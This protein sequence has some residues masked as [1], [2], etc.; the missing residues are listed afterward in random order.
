MKTSWIYLK[1][2]L[3][4][5]VI[6]PVCS[7]L[8]YFSDHLCDLSNV[9]CL[10]NFIGNF[11]NFIKLHFKVDY[12][13]DDLRLNSTFNE[14]TY[15]F[16]DIV[17]LLFYGSSGSGKWGI[18]QTNRCPL[19]MKLNRDKLCFS[20]GPVLDC[21]ALYSCIQPLLPSGICCCREGTLCTQY[22]LLC[23]FC[24]RIQDDLPERVSLAP[25]TFTLLI[26]LTTAGLNV[27]NSL[28]L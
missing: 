14:H 9:S 23:S 17:N 6:K 13:S 19:T 10:I 22:G 26:G 3:I 4:G 18:L 8:F 24:T 27:I 20:S 11:H 1:T 7:Q 5:N 25:L 12:F 2:Y 21:P 28:F 16:K 15:E